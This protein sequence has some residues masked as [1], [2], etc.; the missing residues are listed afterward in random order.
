[1]RVGALHHTGLVVADLERS[2]RFYHDLLG[3]PVRERVEHVTPDV[4]A[5]GGWQGQQ[6]RI[7]DL[8]LGDGRVLELIELTGRRRPE[9]STSPCRWT[10]CALPGGL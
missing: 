5:V 3:I 6:A 7:A 2:L 10:T 4:V 8:D 1:V 9:A